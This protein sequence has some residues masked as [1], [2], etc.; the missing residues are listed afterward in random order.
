MFVTVRIAHAD[1]TEIGISRDASTMR[2]HEMTPRVRRALGF[3]AEGE[4]TAE[5]VGA[6]ATGTPGTAGDQAGSGRRGVI[7]AWLPG[8]SGGGAGG[9]GHARRRFGHAGGRLGSFLG[10][11]G[12]AL[13]TRL[14][15]P[16][17]SFGVLRSNAIQR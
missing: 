15:D 12:R 8:A 6:V 10:K 2:I 7:G 16:C 4:A 14:W 1:M 5:V 17:H 3:F 9:F 11:P 13:Q